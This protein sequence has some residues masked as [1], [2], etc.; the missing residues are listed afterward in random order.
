[1]RVN[2]ISAIKFYTESK[3]KQQLDLAY[4]EIEN[5]LT[6]YTSYKSYY[7]IDISSNSAILTQLSEENR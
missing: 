3:N 2:Y 5:F 1:M 6:T 4:K 7:N